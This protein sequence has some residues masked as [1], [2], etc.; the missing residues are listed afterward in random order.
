MWCSSHKSNNTNCKNYP[1]RVLVWIMRNNMIIDMFGKQE[2][3]Y[4]ILL[5]LFCVCRNAL[6]SY[7]SGSTCNTITSK[8]LGILLRRNCLYRCIHS[9]TLCWKKLGAHLIRASRLSMFLKKNKYTVCVYI[10]F[11]NLQNWLKY[12]YYFVA[13][14]NW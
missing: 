4:A 5:N 2:F 3:I 9:K 6:P 12:K 10:V 8:V 11:W 7:V 14:F 13:L 1:L